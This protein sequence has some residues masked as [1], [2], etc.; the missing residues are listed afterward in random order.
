MTLNDLVVIGPFAAAVGVAI[1]VLIV[2]LIAPGRRAPAL[3]VSLGGL[4]LVALL[5][6]TT[7]FAVDGGDGTA[8]VTAFGGAYVVDGLT[9]FLDLLFI[10]IVAFTIVFGPDYLEPRGLPIAEFSIVLLFAM[11]GAMLLAASA[12]LLV[13]F[14]ALELMV[15]GAAYLLWMFQR[16]FFGELS[17]FL[18]GRSHHLDDLRPVETLTL[19]PLGALVVVFGLFPGLLLTLIQPTVSTVMGDALTGQAINLVAFLQ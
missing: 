5:T 13:L 8:R 16:V 11:T 3:V 4:A 7:G 14:I 1:A 12:D 15:L 9:T 2:D 17:E 10:A 6:I 19:V 18:Q